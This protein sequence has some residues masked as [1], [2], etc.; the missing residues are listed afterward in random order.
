MV[1]TD[2][3]REIYERH[4]RP[5]SDAERLQLLALVANGLARE[6]APP[7]PQ[8]ATSANAPMINVLC[9][10][11]PDTDCTSLLALSMRRAKRTP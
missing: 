7:D 2:R 11:P 10:C 9:T 4:V 5:L 1:A 3:V 8:P 6:A